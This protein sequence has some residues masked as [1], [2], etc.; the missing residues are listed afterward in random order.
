[1]AG[2]GDS[3]THTTTDRSLPELASSEAAW[4]LRVGKRAGK[5]GTGHVR[6]AR[7]LQIPGESPPEPPRGAF[8][9]GPEKGDRGA[10]RHSSEGEPDSRTVVEKRYVPTSGGGEQKRS[11]F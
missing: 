10:F 1:M 4:A 11:Q 8:P 5:R 9:S 2:R 7:C 3:S 6:S